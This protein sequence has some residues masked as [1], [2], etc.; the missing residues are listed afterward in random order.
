[1][2][3]WRAARWAWH[4]LAPYCMPCCDTTTYGQF[5]LWLCLRLHTDRLARIVRRH[6]TMQSYGTLHNQW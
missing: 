4:G 3:H 1:L 6:W 2:T 5:Q